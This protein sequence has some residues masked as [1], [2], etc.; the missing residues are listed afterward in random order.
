MRLSIEIYLWIPFIYRDMLQQLSYQANQHELIAESFGI[1]FTKEV[2]TRVLEVRKELKNNKKEAALSKSNLE[3]SYKAL[4]DS[5]LKY[6]KSHNAQETAKMNYDKSEV[7][8]SFSR[9]DVSK[10]KDEFV[11]K[12]RDNDECKGQYANQLGKTNKAQEVIK[13]CSFMKKIKMFKT[14]IFTGILQCA[15]S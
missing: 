4:D 13:L 10:L 5:K 15:F 1:E 3:K 14:Y 9:N 6:Q 8:G 11:R 12:T 2:E 7:D